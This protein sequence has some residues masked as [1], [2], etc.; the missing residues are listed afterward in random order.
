[1]AE[2]TQVTKSKKDTF[3]ERVLS[4]R[5]DLNIDNEDEYYAALSEDYDNYDNQTKALTEE[6]ERYKNNEKMIVDF[7]TANKNNGMYLDD[8]MN[9][10]DIFE[11]A[12]SRH[13]YDGVLEYLQSEEAR[14]KYRAAD[15]EYR[16]RLDRNKALDEEST[17]N[18][19]KTDK[20]L[21][22]AIEEGRFTRDECTKAIDFLMDI[23]DGLNVNHCKPEW[24]EMA[25][26]AMNHDNDVE[27]ARE[28]GRVDGVN[29]G[30][31]KQMRNKKVSGV[32][33]NSPSMPVGAG[34]KNPIG[35]NNGKSSTLAGALFGN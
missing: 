28:E 27:T 7:V 34:G 23:N 10:K 30:V 9:G 26:K 5:P 14:E 22:A 32:P 21:L 29:E 3:N 20:A 2:N 6:N 35:K 31:E 11:S 33:S 4:K 17:K 12:V 1:M 16:N 18:L 24:I 15:E 13:G 19:A 25:L 8:L